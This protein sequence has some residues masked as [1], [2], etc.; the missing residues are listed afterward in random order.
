MFGLTSFH[1]SSYSSVVWCDYLLCCIHYLIWYGDSTID[2]HRSFEQILQEAL[3][4]IFGFSSLLG[5]HPPAVEWRAEFWSATQQT[6]HDTSSHG[7]SSIHGESRRPPHYRFPQDRHHWS[8]QITGSR[9]RFTGYHLHLL[10]L[11]RQLRPMLTI[12]K[13]VKSSI[14]MNAIVGQWQR[15]HL[16]IVAQDMFGRI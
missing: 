4:F 7:H 3:I 9:G 13:W 5:F 15:S 10:Y 1:V 14:I 6:L 11:L 12:K 8:Q 2:V 16:H